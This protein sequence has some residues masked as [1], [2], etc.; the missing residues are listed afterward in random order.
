MIPPVL[1]GGVSYITFGLLAITQPSIVS[2]RLPK[3]P[4]PASFFCS[5]KIGG[6][7]PRVSG[8]PEY[9]L[10]SVAPPYSTPIVFG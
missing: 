4:R 6:G 3:Y 8:M 7:G 10:L 9:R 2:L 1:V 5:P